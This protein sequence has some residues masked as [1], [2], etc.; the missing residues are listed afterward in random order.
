MLVF[1]YM[2]V[3]VYVLF[4]HLQQFVDMIA[5]KSSSLVGLPLD[6]QIIRAI[7][8]TRFLL[9]LIVKG[10]ELSGL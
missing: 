4:T 1:Y 5:H 2:H 8:W 7:L 3:C 6:V 10:R 9:D